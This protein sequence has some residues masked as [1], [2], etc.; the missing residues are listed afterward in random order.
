M[1]CIA[2]IMCWDLR[3]KVWFWVVVALLQ[4]VYV[5]LAYLA[6]WPKV[7]TMTKLTMLPYGVMYYCLTVG[8]LKILTKVTKSSGNDLDAKSND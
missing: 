5:S 6:H 7:T 4:G 1:N 3:K 2:I 8:I